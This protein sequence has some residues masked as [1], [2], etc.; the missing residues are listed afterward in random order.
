MHSFGEPFLFPC[1]S[2]IGEKK[3]QGSPFLAGAI[4]PSAHRLTNPVL[5]A[6]NSAQHSINKNHR[7]PNA[8]EPCLAALFAFGDQKCYKSFGGVGAF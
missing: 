8:N 6:T 3:G 2:T 5:V 4:V 1:V 7:S